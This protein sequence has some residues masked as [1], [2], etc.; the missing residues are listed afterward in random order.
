[1]SNKLLTTT[2]HHEHNVFPPVCSSNSV[3]LLSMETVLMMSRLPCFLLKKGGWTR[4]GYLNMSESGATCPLGLT[5]RQYN[6]I[7]HG[8]CGRTNSSGASVLQLC[9]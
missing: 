8:V 6:N 4:V 3:L 2:P 7:D 5:K 1:M 9:F